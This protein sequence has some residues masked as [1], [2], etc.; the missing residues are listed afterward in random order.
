MERLRLMAS[1]T[2]FFFR[3]LS[4]WSPFLVSPG[5]HFWFLLGSGKEIAGCVFVFSHKALAQHA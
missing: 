1:L 3:V 5:H 2:R 4:V